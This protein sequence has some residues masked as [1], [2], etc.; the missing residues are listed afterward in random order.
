[1]ND[2]VNTNIE[3]NE[4]VDVKTELI[5]PETSAEN[6]EKLADNINNINITEG[7][8]DEVERVDSTEKELDVPVNSTTPEDST[9]PSTTT[10]ENIN[11]D[12]INDPEAP[13]QPVPTEETKSVVENSPRDT[14]K[15]FERLKI[16]QEIINI[17]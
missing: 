11:I 7:N 16:R 8:T 15:K 10:Y 14:G 3:P 6:I 17:C 12:N 4:E 9:P 13:L 2:T 5:E 1:M